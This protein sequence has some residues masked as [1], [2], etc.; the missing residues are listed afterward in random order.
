MRSGF[1]VSVLMKIMREKHFLSE[2][3][4][5]QSRLRKIGLDEHVFF[6]L[7]IMEAI[8]PDTDHATLQTA[9]IAIGADYAD[10]AA[11]PS[12]ASHV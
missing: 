7:R 3:A 8:A 5:D 1:S 9:A 11:D 2:R 10:A 6:I 4:R 12:P